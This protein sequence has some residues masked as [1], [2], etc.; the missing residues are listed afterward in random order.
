MAN[1]L[2]ENDKILLE[3][4]KREALMNRERQRKFYEKN[5]DRVNKER[6]ER[7]L[8]KRQSYQKVL[9][10][11]KQI[12]SGQ[13]TEAENDRIN[14]IDKIIEFLKKQKISDGTMKQRI[15]DTKRFLG[16]LTSCE[17]LLMCLKNSEK[18]L[19][20]IKNAKMP[21]GKPYSDNTKKSALQSIL[22]LI[23][24][25]PPLKNINKR[26]F[27]EFY[28]L[29][30]VNNLVRVENLQAND[31]ETFDFNQMVKSVKKKYGEK[32]RE[33]LLISFYDNLTA[34]DDYN[35]LIIFDENIQK[36]NPEDIDKKNNNYLVI[37]KTKTR[38]MTIIL[39]KYKTSG[40]YKTINFVIPTK[41]KNLTFDFIKTNNLS[42]G[43]PLF[44]K[45]N[46]LSKDIKAILNGVDINVSQSINALRHSKI[47]TEFKKIS[48]EERIKL[49]K[50][51]AHSP[52]TQVSYLRKLEN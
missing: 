48:P 18:I 22:Y 31:D 32:S 23:D 14:E 51:M 9:D 2:T 27:V 39:N 28:D 52:I 44:G 8:L 47:S 15:N 41:L 5:R 43:D 17:D 50:K 1:L 42:H 3:K 45:K 7:Y 25:Y 33:F 12:E 30:K 29:M 37:S 46:S 49:T 6:R 35:N 38:K 34:R 21:N 24:N 19:S 40:K 11:S 26:P 20:E 13:S 10:K 16:K 36:Y 4:M